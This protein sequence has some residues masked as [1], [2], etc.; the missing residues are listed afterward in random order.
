MIEIPDGR[1]EAIGKGNPDTA[2]VP[3][4]VAVN[5][6]GRNYDILANVE[7]EDT[8][9]GWMIFVRG[10]RFGGHALVVKD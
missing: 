10:S 7:I 1:V 3:G 9:A 6:R 5:I 4:G 2:C 8:N